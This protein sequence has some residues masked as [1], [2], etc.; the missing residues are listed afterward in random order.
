MRGTGVLP[1]CMDPTT[2]YANMKSASV[3]V[4]NF[5]N[6]LQFAVHVSVLLSG[7]DLKQFFILHKKANDI[8]LR[9]G[10]SVDIPIMFAPEEM[11]RHE[12]TATIIANARYNDGSFGESAYQMEH[13]LHWEYP[14][15]GQP[16]L[17]LCSN[18][19]APMIMCRAKEQLEQMVE[20]TLIKSLKSTAKIF[21]KQPG[22][23]VEID[24]FFILHH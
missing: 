24:L 14:I 13:G 5:V 8:F 19:T 1:S 10:Q 3:H 9:R 12:I 7:K 23:N 22:R 4:I 15:Y 6:P 20:V 2:V 17:R 11:Y 18:D 21:L 16:E